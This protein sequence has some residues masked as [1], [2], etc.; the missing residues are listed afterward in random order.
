MNALTTVELVENINKHWPHVAPLLTPPRADDEYERLVQALDAILDAGGADENHELATLAERMGE[1]VA[2][3]ED[4]N[5]IESLPGNPIAVL[6]FL[7][8]QHGL[9]QADLPEIGK[10]SVVSAILNG[11]RQL[12]LN[13]VKAL[14]RRFN[15]PMDVFVAD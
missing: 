2:A 14:A 7:M 12:N 11:K 9:R 10:Q 6:Q 4:A 3:Y 15:V 8:E 5:D 1:L 13:Q